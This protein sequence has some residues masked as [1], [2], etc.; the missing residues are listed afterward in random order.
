MV[1]FSLKCYFRLREID[2]S[3]APGDLKLF[4]R[5]RGVKNASFK[6]GDGKS[7]L[8]SALPAREAET[9]HASLHHHLRRDGYTGTRRRGHRFQ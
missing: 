5:C 8:D 1:V 7:C 2:V 4:I 3:I 6:K 9:R